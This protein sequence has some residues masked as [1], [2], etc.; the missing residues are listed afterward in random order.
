VRRSRSLARPARGLKAGI[1]SIVLQSL[2]LGAGFALAAAAQPGPLQAFLLSQVAE[3]GWR[4][5]LPA[6]FAPLLSDGPIAFVAVLLLGRLSEGLAR[7]L[8]AAG[9]LLLLYLAWGAFREWRREALVAAAGPG[10]PPRTLLQAAAVNLLNPNPYLGWALVLGPA[11]VS[12]WHRHPAH[13]VALVVSFYATM[14]VALAAS[15]VLLGTTRWL[16][17]RGRRLLVLVSAIILAALGASR[18]AAG[19]RLP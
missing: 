12:A 15:I 6:A 13:G 5:T 14:V 1:E 8:E 3:H 19:I 11:L 16:G 4:R 2:L 10:A 7:A 9:G 18:L 17:P